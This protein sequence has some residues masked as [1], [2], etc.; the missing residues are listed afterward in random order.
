M[1]E[2]VPKESQE[3]FV[4]RDFSP[5]G[6]RASAAMPTLEPFNTR[7]FLGLPNEIKDEIWEHLIEKP[8]LHFLAVVPDIFKNGKDMIYLEDDSE[9]EA[10]DELAVNPTIEIKEPVPSSKSGFDFPKNKKS[11]YLTWAQLASAPHIRPL[12]FVVGMIKPFTIG[13]CLTWKATVDA[14]DDLLYLK[15]GYRDK[16]HRGLFY[17]SWPAKWMGGWGNRALEGIC[18]V[19]LEFPP[20]ERFNMNDP[21]R[22]PFWLD[23]VGHG[24]CCVVENCPNP[25]HFCSWCDVNDQGHRPQ[26]IRPFQILAEFLHCLPDLETV[27]LVFAN[28]KQGPFSSKRYTV[29]GYPEPLKGAKSQRPYQPQRWETSPAPL[30]RCQGG[31]LT[32]MHGT[33][34]VRPLAWLVETCQAYYVFHSPERGQGY[35][36]PMAQRKLGKRMRVEF[37]MAVWVDEEELI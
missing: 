32:E 10:D 7:R 9:S 3:A 2:N 12:V 26:V 29:S 22:C 21:A 11:A 5:Q 16:P 4:P 20:P 28:V 18:N 6:V 33:R 27:Y 14:A 13:S 30:F 31:A 34:I 36:P 19:A 25:D 24:P 23:V 17:K 8:G 15:F 37:K 1:S 35:D